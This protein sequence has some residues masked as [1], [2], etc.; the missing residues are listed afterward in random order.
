[1]DTPTDDWP[2]PEIDYPCDWSYKLVGPSE[3]ALR[4]VI[5]EVVE[6]REHT[7]KMSRMSRT[8]RYVSLSVHVRVHDHDERR[9]MADAFHRHEAVAFVL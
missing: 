2:E 4:A 8:G 1:M 6:D 9:G 5:A 7:V 3:P